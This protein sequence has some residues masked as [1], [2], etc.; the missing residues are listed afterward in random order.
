MDTIIS[1]KYLNEITFQ[2]IGAA[3]DVQRN[4]GRGLLERVYH[5]CMKEELKHRKINFQTE[6]QVPLLYKGK[7]LS[8]DFRCDLLVEDCLLVELKAVNE[9]NTMFEAQLLTYMKL[10]QKPKGLLMNFI[11]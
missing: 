9:M 10:L 3:I 4:I 1:K 6:M 2:V 7:I 11:P 8:T 5:E